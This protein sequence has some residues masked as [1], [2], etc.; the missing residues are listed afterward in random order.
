VRLL[1]PAAER[2][3][4]SRIEEVQG[5]FADYGVTTTFGI[6]SL[7][8]PA[9]GQGFVGATDVPQQVLRLAT[10]AVEEV[11]PVLHVRAELNCVVRSSPRMTADVSPHAQETPNVRDFGGV[12]AAL[13]HNLEISPRKLQHPGSLVLVAMHDVPL[14]HNVAW[15]MEIV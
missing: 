2:V 11:V 1:E 12:G 3:Q 6:V 7:Q 8:Q 4:P 13:G 5:P 14:L 9:E 10:N 15:E